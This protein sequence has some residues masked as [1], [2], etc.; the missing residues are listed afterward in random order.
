[1][2][3]LRTEHLQLRVTRAQKSA[4]ARSAKRAGMDMTTWLLSKALSEPAQRFVQLVR[5]LARSADRTVWAELSDVLAGLRPQEFANAVSDLPPVRLSDYTANYLAAM[6]ELAAHQKGVI[7]PHWTADIPALE[8][9]VFGSDLQSLRLH[10]LLHSP[11]PF[12]AR[13]IFIDSSVGDRV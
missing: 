10:L 9:P 12:R 7:A 6:V 2:Q 8:T 4:I 11:P 13:N 3:R 5:E 1:M